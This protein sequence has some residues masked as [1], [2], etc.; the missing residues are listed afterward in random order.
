LLHDNGHSTFE[1]L[2]ERLAR[3]TVRCSAGLLGLTR[4]PSPFQRHRLGLEQ[5]P[6]YQLAQPLSPDDGWEV[7]AL[8]SGGFVD[9]VSPAPAIDPLY[10]AWA[11]GSRAR[12]GHEIVGLLPVG[13]YLFVRSP[14]PLLTTTRVLLGNRFV[15]ATP[16]MRVLR[17]RRPYYACV[18]GPGTSRAPDLS[19]PLLSLIILNYAGE[20]SLHGS[21]FFPFSTPRGDALGAS[22]DLVLIVPEEGELVVDNMAFFSE[23]EERRSKQAWRD[24]QAAEFADWCAEEP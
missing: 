3:L 14:R 1:V 7:T 4:D 9:V 16:H 15:P 2:S 20:A 24:R 18:I 6:L 23:E 13:R 5:A 19:Q 12:H 8:P 10:E 11:V 17:E 22:Q 21:V